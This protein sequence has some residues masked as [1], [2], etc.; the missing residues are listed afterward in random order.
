MDFRSLKVKLGFV[1]MAG[2][3]VLSIGV[4]PAHANSI[5]L[6]IAPGSPT[7]AAGIWTYTYNVSVGA[8]DFFS[9]AN[10]GRNGGPTGTLMTFYD[11]NGYIGGSATAAI[12]GTTWAIST[13]LTGVTPGAVVVVDNAGV[14]NVVFTYSTVATTTF[15]L[16]GL[17][18]TVSLQSIEGPSANSLSWAGQDQQGT[19]SVDDS[20]G[21][22]T[23]PTG[24]TT[25]PEPSSLVLLGTGLLSLGAFRS[26]RS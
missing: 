18:G 25:V 24:Q 17:I 26:K 19:G 21:S 15:P 12:A 23:G 5:T 8:G 13:P 2:I 3:F 20:V 10:P 6:N 16:G 9:T 14:V 22:T 1:L 4:A 7:L 11:F